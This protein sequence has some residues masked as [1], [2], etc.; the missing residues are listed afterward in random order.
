MSVRKLVWFGIGLAA[1]GY[2]VDR[3]RRN[4][5]ARPRPLADHAG[6][7]LEPVEVE[8]EGGERIEAVEAGSGPTLLLIPGLSGDK[9]VFRYQLP[10]LSERYRVIAA[11]LRVE[12][13]GVE[14]D[15][16]RF[17]HDVGD[18]LDAFGAHDAILLGL[19]FG[20]PIAL[21]FA[22]LHPDRV[23]ALVLTNT[24]VRLDLGHVGLNKTL[25]IPLAHLTSRFLPEPLMRRMGELW[26]DLGVWIYDPSPG[27][28]R[29]ID[30]QLE[31]PLRTPMSVGN[32]RME[33]FRDRDLRPDLP[34]I[35]QPA[36][37][38][39]GAA[40]E[41]TPASWQREIAE[42][43]P[44]ATFVEIPNAGHLALISH[45]ETF[46]R[47]VGDWLDELPRLREIAP[48]AS[49]EGG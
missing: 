16:D 21:R 31:S 34:S 18:V 3:R 44:N 38:V 47:V 30:Y 40:D 36:L 17:A 25:L 28:D 10:E 29:V 8:L 23:R 4:L 12:F 33:T 19:S 35:E 24:L 46:N 41:Y 48:R 14:R 27:N 39:R 45:A 9:E 22:T 7:D 5:S 6:R 1:G 42:L 2:L 26:G 11:D 37:V 32:K 49:G 13:T 20:G 15:F 43:L